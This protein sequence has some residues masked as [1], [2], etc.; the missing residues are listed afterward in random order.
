MQLYLLRHGIAEKNSRTGEDRDRALT[1]DGRKKLRQV[2]EAAANAGV[3]PSLILSSPFKRTTETAKIAQQVL[4]YKGDITETEALVPDSTV[5]RVWREVRAH[6]AE[7]S[8]MLVGHNPLFAELAGYLLGSTE[9]QID[10]KKGSLLRIDMASLGSH[11]KGILRWH[12]TAKLSD[13]SS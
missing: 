7:D 4:K 13:S 1:S 12:L 3:N 8:L 11:P 5:E 9:I 6:R 2:L 10:V